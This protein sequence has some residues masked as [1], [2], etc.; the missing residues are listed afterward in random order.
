M[1]C[2]IRFI[3]LT[4]TLDKEEFEAQ[5]DRALQ[6]SEKMYETDFGYADES[7]IKSGISFTYYNDSKKKKI[8][9]IVYCPRLLIDDDSNEAWEPTPGNVSK[10]IGK[11]DKLIAK[12]FRF[13]YGLGD[14]DLAR[15]DLAVN[16]QVGKEQV[17]DYIKVLHNIRQVKFF[18]PMK[19]G[20]NDGEAKNECFGLVGNSNGIEF[21]AHGVKY[22]KKILRTEVRLMTKGVIRAFT[23]E[24][25]PSEQLKVIAEKSARI[26]L[27]TFVNIVPPGDH[28]K[29]VKAEQLIRERV[30]EW[31][32]R[33]KML[34]LLTLIPKKKSLHLGQK[35]IDY[36]KLRGIMSAFAEINVSPVTIS[37]RHAIQKLDSLYSYLEI[38]KS[39]GD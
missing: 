22:D 35:A 15:V 19:Y 5:L 28:Y 27:E 39:E 34:W 31:K 26:F 2:F 8:R 38:K 33:S 17:S 37:K 25:D 24:S 16:F 1:L 12:Y 14:F 32:M 7:L 9:V 36:R 20:R 29:K 21:R 6:K 11:L 30:L 3:E 23:E 4:M 13:E 10:L 18:T